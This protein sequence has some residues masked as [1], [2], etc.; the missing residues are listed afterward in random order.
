MTR[1]LGLGEFRL[2]LTRY[3]N[4]ERIVFLLTLLLFGIFVLALPNFLSTAN[5]LSLLRSVAVLGIL[6]VGML[7]VVLGGVGLSGAGSD[8]GMGLEIMA[9]TATITAGLP[10]PKA[11]LNISPLTLV[12]E[13]RSLRGSYLGS[14]AP[15]RDIPRFLGLFRRGKLA[16]DKLLTHRIALQDVNAGLDRL[17][18]GEAIRQVIE[19]EV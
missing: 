2:D 5:M 15:S 9:L 6:G 17:H 12:A 7:I 11:V 14:G 3:L 13:E 8:T 18:R 19:F 16:V 10:N 4:Q 1:S